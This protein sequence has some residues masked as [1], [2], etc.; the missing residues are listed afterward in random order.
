MLAD[1]GHTAPAV[2]GPTKG[3]GKGKGKTNG[4]SQATGNKNPEISH[5]AR[6]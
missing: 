5:G 6:A 1:F 2:A 3:K 4:G